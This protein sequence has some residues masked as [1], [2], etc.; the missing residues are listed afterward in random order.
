MAKSS[1][2]KMKI[3]FLLRLFQEKTEENPVYPMQTLVEL[4]A[5]QGISAERKSIYDDL[6]VLRQFGL[7][8]R[9]RKE[10]PSGYYLVR[11]AEIPRTE[12]YAV[13][14]G[15]SK[16]AE[17]ENVK[18]LP[19]AEEIPKPEKTP[20]SESGEEISAKDTASESK[21]T[22]S[23]TEDSSVSKAKETGLAKIK[24]SS[25]PEAEETV[26]I[27]P[28]GSFEPEAEKNISAFVSEEDT[29]LSESEELISARKTVKKTLP[30]WELLFREKGTVKTFK[31][32]CNEKGKN[33]ALSFFGDTAFCKRKAPGSY[34]VS[35]EAVPG[36][37]F[38]GWLTSVGR[39]IHIQKPKKEAAAYRDYLKTIAKDYKNLEK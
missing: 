39:D 13:V 37:L 23:Q 33:A 25:E 15:Q 3:L 7:D 36:P 28:E 17:S 26:L 4:L 27:E 19:E 11:D 6:E 8:I 20:I 14:P 29:E 38:Y 10:R 22:I 31:L 34:L 32:L 5:A 18:P 30:S 24:D 35:G 21:I 12:F 2:Q 16:G 1:N 9:F